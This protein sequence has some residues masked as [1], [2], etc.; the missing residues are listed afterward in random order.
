MYFDKA[1]A[2]DPKDTGA[3]IGK[4]YTLD[5]SG[6]STGAISSVD[7][8]L[9]IDPKDPDALKAKSDLTKG[10]QN[11]DNMRIQSALLPK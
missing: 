6:N 7:K 9:A 10:W 5:D 4:G 11:P 3:L 2:I 8:A 1:L